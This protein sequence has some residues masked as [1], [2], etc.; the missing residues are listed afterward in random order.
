MLEKATAAEEKRKKDIAEGERRMAKERLDAQKKLEKLRDSDKP[1]NL[2][3][4]YYNF[5][6]MSSTWEP[7]N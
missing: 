2:R 3:P 6:V 7:Q 4:A 1:S 5:T